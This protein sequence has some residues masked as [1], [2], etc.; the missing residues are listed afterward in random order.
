M[1][2]LYST[3][4]TGLQLN[5]CMKFCSMSPPPPNKI[6]VHFTF[7]NGKFHFVP[8]ELQLKVTR[9]FAPLMAYDQ[10]L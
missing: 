4:S 2:V 1:I 9:L 3:L 10:F 7:C 5:S 8:L 6:L